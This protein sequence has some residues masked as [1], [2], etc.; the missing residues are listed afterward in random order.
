MRLFV[1]MLSVWVEFLGVAAVAVPSDFSILKEPTTFGHDISFQSI[2]GGALEKGD[3]KVLRK[4]ASGGNDSRMPSLFGPEE[5]D[6]SRFSACLAAT[7]GLRR[8][9]DQALLERN[10][11]P[12]GSSEE[13]LEM[14]KQIAAQYQA[15]SARVLRAMGMPVERFNELGQEISRDD[16]LK[17]KVGTGK[18]LYS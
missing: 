17:E 1:L 5:S 15:N 14:E 11:R 13:A 18:K 9:R 12:S 16:K 10:Y 6:Y 7:E 3:Q 2:R 8:M 4:F